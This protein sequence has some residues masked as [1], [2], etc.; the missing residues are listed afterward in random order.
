MSKRI[1]IVVCVILLIVLALV[2]YIGINNN[3]KHAEVLRNLHVSQTLNSEEKK[4][5]ENPIEFIA[6]YSNTNPNMKNGG[7]LYMIYV[8]LIG[9]M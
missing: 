4:N 2:I 1:I 3:K 8:P 9:L 5:K 6:E 7:V